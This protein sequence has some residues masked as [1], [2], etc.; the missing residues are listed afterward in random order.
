MQTSVIY[1]SKEGSCVRVNAWLVT[2]VDEL[3]SNQEEADTKVILHSGHAIS[4]TEGSIILR[5][6]SGDI[7]IMIIAISLIDTSKRVLVDYGNGKNRK[8]VWLNSIDFDD[9]IR[10]A[11]IGFRALLETIMFRRFLSV[12]SRVASKL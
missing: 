9:N 1:F 5:S 4:T 11:L 6:S 3:S 7:D 10:A 8:G 12:V 2:P